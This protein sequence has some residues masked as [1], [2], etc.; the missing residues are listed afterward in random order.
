MWTD[1]FK[2]A[3]FVVFVISETV[4]ISFFPFTGNCKL[5]NLLSQNI[6]KYLYLYITTTLSYICISW[7]RTAALQKIL[8]S[9]FPALPSHPNPPNKKDVRQDEDRKWDERARETKQSHYYF[10]LC[11]RL[12]EVEYTYSNFLFPKEQV[13]I[14]EK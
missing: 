8:T 11:Y 2:A 3:P 1:N 12:K 7:T 4:L 13:I 10:E 9:S 14:L 6:Y 5:L